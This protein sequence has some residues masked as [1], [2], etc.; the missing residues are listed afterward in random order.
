MSEILSE[1][2]HFTI[3]FTVVMCVFQ[4]DWLLYIPIVIYSLRL[5]TNV[6][7]MVVM[8]INQSFRLLRYTNRTTK[9]NDF[10]VIQFSKDSHIIRYM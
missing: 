8:D 4:Y 6:T 1:F 10:P 7:A 3:I 5:F 2:V 9:S